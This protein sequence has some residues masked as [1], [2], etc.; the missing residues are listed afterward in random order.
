MLIWFF[1]FLTFLGDA[2]VDV[3]EPSGLITSLQTPA[4]L[5]PI[6]FLWHKIVRSGGQS[7]WPQRLRISDWLPD[8]PNTV[9]TPGLKEWVR[10]VCLQMWRSCLIQI[11]GS[12]LLSFLLLSDALL[13]VLMQNITVSTYCILLHFESEKIPIR[14][15][16]PQTSGPLFGQRAST[17][18]YTH[19]FSAPKESVRNVFL[20][21]WMRGAHHCSRPPVSEMTYTASTGTL[22]STIHTYIHTY[23]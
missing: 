19:S 21:Y 3:L 13:R 11:C 2:R 10:S 12:S 18:G 5:W 22:N 23:I 4:C 6:H 8:F 1:P 14:K 15:W 7:L 9:R 16:V 20:R 17:S